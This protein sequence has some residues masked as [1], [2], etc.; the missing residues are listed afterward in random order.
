[1]NV[2]NKILSEEEVQELL[3]KIPSW[4]IVD[5]EGINP[6]VQYHYQLTRLLII[7]TWES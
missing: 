3:P 5:D 6:N 1:M 4:I 2:N 7:H